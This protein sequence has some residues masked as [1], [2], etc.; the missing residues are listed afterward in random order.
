MTPELYL[1]IPPKPHLRSHLDQEDKSEQG[2]IKLCFIVLKAERIGGILTHR[3]SQEDD[4][5]SCR[6]LGIRR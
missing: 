5:M 4:L 2:V 1:I 6:K 3:G